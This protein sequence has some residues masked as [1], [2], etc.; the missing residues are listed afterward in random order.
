MTYDNQR[1]QALRALAEAIKAAPDKGAVD[2]LWHDVE[3]LF[4]GPVASGPYT[5]PGEGGGNGSGSGGPP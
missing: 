2:E 5:P 3:T 1:E 4:N